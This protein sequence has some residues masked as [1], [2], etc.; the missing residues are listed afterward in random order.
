MDMSAVVHEIKMLFT[1]SSEI[2]R[3]PVSCVRWARSTFFPSGH[4]GTRR[5]YNRL[6]SPAEPYICFFICLGSWPE[7]PDEFD[8][9][10]LMGVPVAVVLIAAHF[11]LRRILSLSL[12]LRFN[13][14]AT[15]D[16]ED[17]RVEVAVEML[18]KSNI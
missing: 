18:P 11:D 7:I 8:M 9:L 17:Q 12:S 16:E 14:D 13:K 4:I 10:L 15:R 5:L 3:P 2:R 6:P 1:E